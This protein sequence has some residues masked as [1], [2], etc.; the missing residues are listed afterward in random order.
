MS[1]HEGTTN[2]AEVPHGEDETTVLELFGMQL[3]VKNRRIAEVLTMEAGDALASDIRNFLDADQVRRATETVERSPTEEEP[4]SQHGGDSTDRPG[5]AGLRARVES[6]AMALG[7]D[8]E[9]GGIWESPTG[10]SV[11]TRVVEHDL[12]YAAATD[13][14]DKVAGVLEAGGVPDATCLLVVDSQQ[15]ADIFKVAIRQRRLYD[16]VRTISL[17]NLEAIRSLLNAGVIDH[18]RALV[19]LT[20]I[21]N[22][23]VGEVLAIIR[24][25]A[26]D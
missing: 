8:V 16:Q 18:S 13:L 24:A 4:D 3:K 9:S 25:A 22:A 7:F 15:S 17:E 14:V 20:P 19:L 6:I 23:D 1:H 12:S 26:H 11:L 21:A 5:R 10:V 2:G